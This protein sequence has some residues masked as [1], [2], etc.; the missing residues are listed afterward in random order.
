MLLEL[1]HAD[2][3]HCQIVIGV[4]HA[5]TKK[6]ILVLGESLK[7][8]LNNTTVTGGLST[9]LKLLEQEKRLF[10]AIVFVCN[11]VKIYQ[12]KAK[13]SEIRPYPLCLGNILKTFT[14]AHAKKN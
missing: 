8:R 4:T 5:T 2:F 12:F 14:V 10:K 13:G 11:G 3:F 6:N 1:I 7:D 9:L